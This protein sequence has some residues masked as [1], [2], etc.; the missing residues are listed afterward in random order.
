M[1]TDQAGDTR[2]V[3]IIP[4]QTRAFIAGALA[5]P[6]AVGV[7][8]PSPL[9]PLPGRDASALTGFAGL[10]PF[11]PIG[12]P[13][14]GA[15]VWALSKLPIPLASSVIIL[16][17]LLAGLCIA[18]IARLLL[19][20]PFRR[21]RELRPDIL[22]IEAR[23]RISAAIFGALFFVASSSFLLTFAYP[24]PES[25]SVTLLLAGVAISAE[26]LTLGGAWRLAVAAALLSLS[27]AEH[28]AAVLIAPIVALAAITRGM[29]Q[30]ESIVRLVI[31]SFVCALAGIGAIAVGIALFMHSQAAEWRELSRVGEALRL[32]WQ[33]YMARGPR[34]IPR[35]V[36]RT[37][38][39]FAFLPL[40]F[41]AMRRGGG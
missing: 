6:G 7:F 16:Q 32:F 41:L 22:H 1:Q 35:V 38:A 18:S 11:R 36:W 13:L 10:H 30:R 34:P 29:M 40:P 39:A 25:L 17:A 3:E 2:I 14:W 23:D 8:A 19:R 9:S 12:T 20:L 33:E 4:P 5:L 37:L 27:A 15:M 24:R 26:H 28:V 21:A 31:P